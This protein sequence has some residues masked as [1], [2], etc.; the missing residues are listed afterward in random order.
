MLRR[1]GAVAVV[2]NRVSIKYE[3]RCSSVLAEESRL[4][5]KRDSHL[6]A[7]HFSKYNSSGW[8]HEFFVD[9]PTHSLGKTVTCTR[10]DCGINQT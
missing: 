9:P 4:K 1:E 6:H 7:R 8:L 10:R 2:G 3:T 5:M